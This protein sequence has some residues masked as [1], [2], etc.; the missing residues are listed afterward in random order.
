VLHVRQHPHQRDLDLVVERPERLVV[1]R[2]G[3]RLDQAVDCERVAPGAVC[4]RHRRA[5]EVELALGGGAVRRQLGRGVAAQHLVEEI[6]RLCGIEQ[7]GGDGSVDREAA[8]VDADV[9]QGAHDRLR[10][11]GGYRPPTLDRL[12]HEPGELDADGVVDEKPDREP[13]DRARRR[14]GHDREAVERCAPLAAL[15]GRSDGQGGARRGLAKPDQQS[16]GVPR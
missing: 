13:G 6:A 7:V 15:P 5:F 4:G 14:I 3:Q 2:L 12:R 8:H 16:R 1:E 11:V 10:L 9:E